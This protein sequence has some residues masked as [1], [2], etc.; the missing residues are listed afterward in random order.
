MWRNSVRK[1]TF[2]TT[3]NNLTSLKNKTASS[4]Q[5]SVDL[6]LPYLVLASCLFIPAE[7]VITRV[8]I[9]ET[10]I[11]LINGGFKTV[12]YGYESSI[13]LFILSLTVFNQFTLFFKG[14]FSQF[15]LVFSTLIFLAFT[16]FQL[17]M[18]TKHLDL[19]CYFGILSSGFIFFFN[20]RK[21]FWQVWL[22]KNW[23]KTF[24]VTFVTGFG[25]LFLLKC[26]FVSTI[27]SFS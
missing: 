8:K 14:L 21:R 3:L 24:R 18:N 23:F 6:L 19:G 2:D 17:V 1:D 26:F 22:Q 5:L 4:F 16:I 7:I 13:F 11:P 25:C 27:P 10:S 20:I 9:D 15:L 12:L